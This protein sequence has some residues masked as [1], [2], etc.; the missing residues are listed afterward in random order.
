MK[1]FL[2]LF[3][4]LVAIGLFAFPNNVK[5]ALID[6]PAVY[7]KIY[8]ATSLT[9]DGTFI[10]IKS[11]GVPDHVSP[12]YAT[13]N[14]LYQTYAGTTPLGYTFVKNPNTIASQTYTFKIPLNPTVA[15]NHAA[16]PLGVIGVALNGVALYNQYAGPNNTPLTNEI[17]SF[18]KYNGHPQATGQYHYH[19]EPLH[20]TNVTTSKTGL[21]GFLLDGFPVYGPQEITAWEITP[22]GGSKPILKTLVSSDLDVYHGHTH[23]TDDFPNGI[24]HYH[25]TANAPYLNGNGYY[26]TAGTITQ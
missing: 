5:P 1:R 20:L 4:I 8:G 25:F 17:A 26:G 10:T 15:S 7:Y 3:T 13:T 11:N 23:A 21:I 12:Y 9:N 19:V 14:Y 16:T 22:S 18:D 24:Y 6:V 2:F